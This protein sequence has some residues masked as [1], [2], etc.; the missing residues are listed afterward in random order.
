MP[1]GEFSDIF[2]LL[3][4]IRSP[5]TTNGSVIY[6]KETIMKHLSSEYHNK[7]IIAYQKKIEGIQQSGNCL[8]ITKHI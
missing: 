6:R 2:T 7:C 8:L 4:T 5:I 1:C 3:S